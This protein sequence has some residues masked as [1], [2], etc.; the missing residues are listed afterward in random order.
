MSPTQSEP[1]LE[2]KGLEKKG[3]ASVF[4]NDCDSTVWIFDAKPATLKDR[5]VHNKRAY[6]VYMYVI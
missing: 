5:H 2:K 1:L 6:D 3:L 4:E